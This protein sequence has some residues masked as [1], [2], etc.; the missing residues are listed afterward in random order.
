ML[1]KGQGVTVDVLVGHFMVHGAQ[2]S[3][4]ERE[5]H[6]GEAYMARADAIPNVHYAALGHIHKAQPAPGSTDFARYCG[7]LMQLDF[8]EA[9]QDKSVIVADVTPQGRRRIDTIPVTAGRQLIAVRDTLEGLG[10]R[11]EELAGSILKVDVITDGPAPGIAD[12]VRAL[13]GEDVLYVRADYPRE[14][15]ELVARAGLPLD[16]LYAAYVAQR[17]ES[18]PSAELMAAFRELHEEVGAAL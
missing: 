5:L 8:G 13:L 14:Q 18:P 1:E 9:G 15:S 7:S 11:V 17:Y 3:G 4:S 6:I 16:E 2:P 12:E 10:R